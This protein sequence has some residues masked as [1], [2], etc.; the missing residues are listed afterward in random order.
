MTPMFDPPHPGRILKN[1]LEGRSIT[2][3]A[4][5]IGIPSGTL[6]KII[7]GQAGITPEISLKLADAFNTSPDFWFK[8]QVDYDF[9]QA[10]QKLG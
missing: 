9:W 4:K 5:R 8:L 7:Q 10:S 2:A 1:E 6:S 3:V